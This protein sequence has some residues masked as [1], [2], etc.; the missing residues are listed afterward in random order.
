[1]HPFGT[2]KFFQTNYLLMCEKLLTKEGAE[3]A[4]GKEGLGKKL[5]ICQKLKLLTESSYTRNY[6]EK[7]QCI[8]E[9]QSHTLFTN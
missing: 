7:T 1:M 3:R 6:K 4:G 2:C 9:E 8:S 5:S